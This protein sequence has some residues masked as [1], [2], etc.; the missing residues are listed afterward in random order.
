MQLALFTK[1][2]VFDLD[3]EFET[4]FKYIMNLFWTPSLI[5]HVTAK[6]S[7]FLGSF[8]NSMVLEIC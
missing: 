5:F 7:P 1:Y 2:F 4:I 6:I 3:I 8:I